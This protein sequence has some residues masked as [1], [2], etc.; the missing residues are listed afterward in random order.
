MDLDAL[1]DAV[2][3]NTG[4]TTNVTERALKFGLT[5]I[6]QLFPFDELRKEFDTPIIAGDTQMNLP[7]NLDQIIELRLITSDTP[8]MSYP[9]DYRRKTWAV[10]RFPDVPQ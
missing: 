6:S 2:E 4:R 8:T 3:D 7:D 1:V 9:L 10:A 5:R